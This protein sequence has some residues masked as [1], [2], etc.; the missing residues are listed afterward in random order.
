[1]TPNGKID[2]DALREPGGAVL[3][4][5]ESVDPRDDVE[6]TLAELWRSILRLDVPVGATDDFFELGGHSLLAVRLFSEIE[7]VFGVRL[8]LAMLFQGATVEHLAAALRPDAGDPVHWSPIVPLR[9]EGT[10]PPLFLIGGVDGSL[11]FYRDLVRRLDADQPVW[12][13]QP[14]G[15][16]GRANPHTRFEELAEHYV[17]ELRKFQPTGPYLIGGHC[18]SGVVAYEMSRQLLEQGEQAALVAI[19]DG[20]PRRRRTTRLEL[21]RRK[22]ADFSQRDLRG[23]ASWIETRVRGL[24]VKVRNRIR[25]AL[26]DILART[27]RTPPRALW[28]VE[29]ASRRALSAYATPS[30]AA[31]ITLFRAVGEVDDSA[32]LNSF[33]NRVAGGGVDIR[34]LFDAGIRHDNM[35]FEPFVGSLAAELEGCIRALQRDDLGDEAA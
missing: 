4:E 12:G 29:A 28:D 16:D 10:R 22:F 20:A 14:R 18:F 9:A 35:L 26:Y 3:P 5:A 33:W 34:P 11:L 7:R 13:L 8:P 21:E 2:R 23:K 32:Y 25:W 6:R 19:I 1:L 27:G 31:E 24:A 17:E 30:S 15:L